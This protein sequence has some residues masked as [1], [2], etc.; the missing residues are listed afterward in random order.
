M[1]ELDQAVAEQAEQNQWAML[2]MT[3]P[4]V[5]PVTSLAFVLNSGTGGAFRAE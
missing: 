3:H 2:L 5:G 1:K 4:G